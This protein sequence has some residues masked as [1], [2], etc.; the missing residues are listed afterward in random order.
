MAQLTVEGD[1][2]VNPNEGRRLRSQGPAAQP[3]IVPLPFRMQQVLL[4]SVD[5][6]EPEEAKSSAAGMGTGGLG[7]LMGG[8][9]SSAED[10]GEFML[11]D[12]GSTFFWGDD[13]QDGEDTDRWDGVE[14][15]RVFCDHPWF[16][17]QP[18]QRI[19]QYFKALMA[20]QPAGSAA[21]AAEFRARLPQL[22]KRALDVV[23]S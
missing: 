16:A 8:H 11:S 19:S 3:Q 10:F 9:G 15:S 12:I 6:P 1:V 7:I 14:S 5:L 23:L 22:D 13:G 17:E 2:Q 4:R 21:A 18:Q 20:Q